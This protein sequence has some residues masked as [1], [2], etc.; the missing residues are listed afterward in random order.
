MRVYFWLLKKMSSNQ[1]GISNGLFL[2]FFVIAVFGLLY[3]TQ[4]ANAASLVTARQVQQGSG[5]TSTLRVQLVRTDT[6]TGNETILNDNIG[7]II[8]PMPGNSIAAESLS[9]DP[10]TN[11]IHVVVQRT[12]FGVNSISVVTVSASTG[13][14]MREVAVPADR[15]GQTDSVYDLDGGQG[16]AVLSNS[17]QIQTHKKLIDDNSQRIDQNQI[18]IERNK[19][20]V[21]M[22][23]ALA[24]GAQLAP[25]E[26]G[27]VSVDFG[28]FDGKNAVAVNG[29]FRL[30]RNLSASAG[31]GV[32]L[33]DNLVGGRAGLR[34]SW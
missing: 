11:E 27:A 33:E 26:N 12:N 1:F 6:I 13:A 8:N 29:G 31:I 10:T 14:F 20:G 15:I 19:Q 25:T 23:M 9:F 24:G 30:N 16:A 4:N 28:T 34:F 3:T 18:E 2:P 7:S 5:P 17:A 32:G 22:A 21:A